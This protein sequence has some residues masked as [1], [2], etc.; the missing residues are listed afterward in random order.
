MDAI[1]I[2]IHSSID[3]ITNSSSELFICNTKSSIDFVNGILE[4]MLDDYNH[5][6]GYTRVFGE[7]FRDPYIITEDNFDYFLNNFILGWGYRG[8]KWAS[9]G[10]DELADQYNWEQAYEKKNKLSTKY[11]YDK[12][13][14]FNEKASKQISD[15]WDIYFNEWKKKN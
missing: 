15:A 11:P 7:V 9:S 14:D 2:K 1:L 6:T 5:D 8:I 4:T 13:I 3:I 12:Y 10:I